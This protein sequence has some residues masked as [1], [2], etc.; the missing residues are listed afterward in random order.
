MS[1]EKSCHSCEHY[2]VCHLRHTLDTSEF[3]K[4]F[5]GYI[6]FVDNLASICKEYKQ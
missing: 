6:E 5:G 4:F 2:N 1:S 3:I